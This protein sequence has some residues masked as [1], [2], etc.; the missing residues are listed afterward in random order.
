ML[1]DLIKG[2]ALLLSLCLL[3]GILLRGQLPW[4]GRRGRRLLTGLLFGSLCIVGMSTPITLAGSGVIFDARSVILS[5]AGLFGGPLVAGVAGAMAAGFRLWLGGAGAPVGVSVILLSALAG[6]LY[7]FLARHKWLS[8][9]FRNLVLFG[10]LLHL[11]VIYC[12]TYLPNE[13]AELIH[14]LFGLEFLLVFAL[15]TALLGSLLLDARRRRRTELALAR[16]QRHLKAVVHAIPDLL[17]VFNDEGRYLEMLTHEEAHLVRS[18]ADLLGKRIS[19]VFAP[20][21]AVSLLAVLQRTLQQGP[22]CH[23]YQIVTLGGQLRWFEGRTHVLGRY[24]GHRN[25][26]VWLARDITERKEREEQIANLAFYDPLTGLPNRRL[27]RERLGQGLK[28]SQRTGQYGAL[29]FFDLDHFKIINDTLGHD[30]GDQL[31][32]Q[33]AARLQQGVRKVDTVARLGG[34][35]FVV[36]LVGLDA[37]RVSAAHHCRRVA[38]K[39]LGELG[40]PYRLAG[41]EHY[42][43]VSMG[44]ALFLGEEHSAET[45]Q[46]HADLA[47]YQAKAAGRNT[48]RFYD[49]TMQVAIK[50]RVILESALRQGLQLR[51]FQPFYQLQINDAGWVLGAEVLVRWQHPER[52]MISPADF[53]PVAEETGLIIPLAEQLLA[54]VCRQLVAWSSQPGFADLSLAVNVSARQVRQEDFV[55]RIIA[56]VRHSGANPQR[57]KLELTESLLLHDMDDMIRKMTALKAFGIGFSLDDFGTGY[58]SLS[59][60]KLLPLEQLKIDQSFVRD[61]LNDPNDAA[62]ARTIIALA[63]SLGLSVIAEGV[64]HESQR[65][66]LAEQGCHTYQGY[67]FGRPGPLER[68]MA[69]LRLDE[70]GRLVLRQ[71]PDA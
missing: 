43:T 47:L 23:E 3:Y 35:E 33:V 20:E 63:D 18:R 2:V 46:R 14:S 65:R 28:E 29:L 39:L 27:L 7:R 22:Q 41:Q 38:E 54:Q 8:L 66:F 34:D 17:F 71:A 16:S 12:F 24:Q 53:I 4:L 1:L 32:Q 70:Q 60:L 57:L 36:L 30:M 67:L 59:Y 45:L 15:A 9:R 11:L 21:Q 61:L 62:I 37:Q 51:Q 42:S 6:L 56:Q 49:E 25:C 55:E 10:L 19:E 69:S 68:F 48:F 64:E 50:Q 5:M 44:L 40:R 58:S 26:I 31:L 13:A 52:G